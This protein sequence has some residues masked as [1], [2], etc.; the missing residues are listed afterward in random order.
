MKR[1]WFQ[2]HL[3]TAVTLMFAASGLLW[4]NTAQLTNGVLITND[5]SI[6][7][8]NDTIP[9]NTR[10][11]PLRHLR[12]SDGV[13]LWMFWSLAMNSLIAITMLSIAARVLESRIHRREARKP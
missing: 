7:F 9:A 8:L 1:K 13:P 6:C 3:S 12:Y 2:I 5:L 10:G 11:W 4:A